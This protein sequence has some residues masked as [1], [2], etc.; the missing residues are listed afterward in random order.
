VLSG[1]VAVSISRQNQMHRDLTATA[2]D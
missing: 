1:L 2:P